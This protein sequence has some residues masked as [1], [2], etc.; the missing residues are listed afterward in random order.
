MSHQPQDQAARDRALT[1]NLSFAVSAPA[2]SGKTGLL[3]QRVLTLLAQCE[4]PEEVLSITFTRKAAAEMQTRIYDALTVAATTE[5]P[6]DSYAVKTWDLARAVLAVSERENWQLLNN[7]NRLRVM[8]IDGLCRTLTQ[9]L[10]VSSGLGVRLDTC[11][12][13]A[14]LYKEACHSL[15]DQLETSSPYQN[16]VRHLFQHLDNNY[17]KIES[18][19][20]NLLAS[21]DQWLSHIFS[22]RDEKQYLENVLERIVSE[23]LQKC[24]LIIAPIASDLVLLAD[25][26]A[27]NLL[28]DHKTSSPVCACKGLTALP[29]PSPEYLPVWFGLVQLLTTDTGTWRKTV[30]KTQGF[31]TGET[32]DEKIIAKQRKASLYEIISWCNE[33]PLLNDLLQ[34]IKLL[35]QPKYPDNQWEFLDSLTQVLPLLAAQLKVVFSQ[36]KQVDF[37]EITQAALLALGDSDTPSDLALKLDYRIQHILIDEFQDTSV[38]QLR[39]LEK[40]TAGWQPN[41][42][43]SLFLVGDGMQSCYSFRGANVGIF[44][45]VRRSGIGDVALEPLDLTVNF[46]SHEAVVNWVNDTFSMAFPVVDDINRGAVRYAISHAFK[47]RSEA[48]ATGVLCYGITDENNSKQLEANLVV[49]LIQQAQQEAPD[50]T[51]AVL[52]RSRPHLRSILR[53]LEQSGLTWQAQEIDPLA[54][55]MAII[56]LLSLTKALLDPSDRIAWLALL[57]SP[58]CGLNNNELFHFVNWN[59]EQDSSAIEEENAKRH[60]F[61]IMTLLTRFLDLDAEKRRQLAL[62]TEAIASLMRF[63][64]LILASWTTRQRNSF[65]ASI[66]GLWLA[67]GGPAALLDPSDIDNTARY[68]NLLS[69]YESGGTIADW[70]IFERAVQRL[71][72]APNSQSNPKLQVMTIH[73]S[74]GLEFDTVIIPGLDSRPRAD[75]AQLLLWQERLDDHGNTDLLMA[76]AHAT[77]NEKDGIYQFVANEMRLKRDYESSRLLYVGCT[78][79]I[80]QLHLIAEVK[81]NDK[82]QLTKPSRSSLLAPIWPTFE[83]QMQPVESKPSAFDEE[84]RD[85]QHPIASDSAM[86]PADTKNELAFWLR[87]LPATWQTP[88]F[89]SSSLLAAFRGHEFDD[90]DNLPER[91][92]RS[93]V[94]ARHTGTVL[95]RYLQYITEQGI[96]VFRQE[97]SDQLTRFWTFQLLQLGLSNLEAHK[98]CTN[99]HNAIQKITQD[100]I[101]Q[102]VLNNQHTESRCEEA[103]WSTSNQGQPRLQI[104]DRTFIAKPPVN[105]LLSAKDSRTCRWI[106]DYKSSQPQEQTVETFLQEQTDLYTAQLTGYAKLFRQQGEAHIRTALY[107][108]LLA[109]FHEIDC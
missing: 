38:A 36:R 103:L 57:R 56:D 109:Y 49:D 86:S 32:K 92:T 28:N 72:A 101:G 89:T 40:L 54:Q 8:T 17:N 10:P 62:S 34:N 68:F 29:K 63:G 71:Y 55:R 59:P 23:T 48:L 50:E 74:K 69:D 44:L 67:L 65:R 79:A 46:R 105:T 104:I 7:K 6:G 37:I 84:C 76:P 81:Y 42:G 70:D 39:L 1:P 96:S 94:I 31:P 24:A 80:R 90:D 108:P 30:N 33:Q 13:P 26:A 21:R 9:Q 73:K 64:Q 45:E 93:S 107:F 61:S 43:R 4:Q 97:A 41:D 12:D 100:P 58:W 51:I 95:H 78:R 106:I 16:S 88:D 83:E 87:R 60:Q 98:A 15:L 91:E 25:Y 66:Q 75:D 20:I 102:W 5:R 82:D 19:L 2:G 27:S 52:V 99:L 47:T 22:S 18:L 11:E 77:G 14:L 3:T 35:P 85:N 53:T